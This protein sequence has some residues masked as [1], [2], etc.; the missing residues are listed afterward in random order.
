MHSYTH[1]FAHGDILVLSQQ[2]SGILYCMIKFYI[3]YETSE[4]LWS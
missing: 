4:I 1:S 2:V 3:Q